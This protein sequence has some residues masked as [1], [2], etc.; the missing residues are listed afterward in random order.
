MSDSEKFP[1]VY[2][3]GKSECEL[4]DAL[5]HELDEHRRASGCKF[6]LVKRDVETNAN[7]RARYGESVPLLVINN[8]E[9]CKYFFDP[10]RFDAALQNAM[11]KLSCENSGEH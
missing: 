6:H 5:A 1:A 2:F 7:W 8:E 3:Y 11:T 10:E 9:V 4:C